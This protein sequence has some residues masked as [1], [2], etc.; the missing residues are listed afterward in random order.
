MSWAVWQAGTGSQRRTPETE[1]NSRTRE[2]W[3]NGMRATTQQRSEEK[4]SDELMKRDTQ[5]EQVNRMTLVR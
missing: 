2:I 3:K 4:K 1:L 5:S